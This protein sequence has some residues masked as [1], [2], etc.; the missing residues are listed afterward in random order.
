MDERVEQKLDR[1]NLGKLY[2]TP[3]EILQVLKETIQWDGRPKY[4][5]EASMWI[6]NL[7]KIDFYCRFHN[8]KVV[9]YDVVPY[10]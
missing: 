2:E 8:N 6:V 1:M 9:C 5:K 3:N 7:S 10:S 4:S